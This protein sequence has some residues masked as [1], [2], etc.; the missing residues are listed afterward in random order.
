MKWTSE[1]KTFAMRGNI[2][3]LAVGI[4]IG[5]GF[6]NIVTSFIQDVI[7]PLILQPAL[8]EA[9]LKHLNDL[10]VFGTVKYGMFLSALINFIVI[11]LVLF[12]FV[13]TVNAAKLNA[14][15][16]APLSTQEQL[17]TEIRDLLRSEH[18]RIS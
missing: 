8:S 2:V 10:T 13:K 7:T 1:F 5:G 4:I 17:L 18:D 15:V 6:S 16:K 11:A 3:D 12:V 14:E 9:N